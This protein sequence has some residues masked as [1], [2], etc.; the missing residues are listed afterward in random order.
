MNSLGIDIIFR[1]HSLSLLKMSIDRKTEC[2]EYV[3]FL[4]KKLEQLEL[5][6]MNSV[7]STTTKNIILFSNT[8]QKNI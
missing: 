3:N 1:A 5:K 2:Y 8:K 6:K 4:N 7:I